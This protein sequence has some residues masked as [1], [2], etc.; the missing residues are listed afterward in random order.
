MGEGWR[1]AGATASLLNASGNGGDAG[2]GSEAEQQPRRL[3]YVNGPGMR[4]HIMQL[5]SAD[6]FSYVAMLHVFVL[7]VAVL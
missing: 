1:A 4:A 6:H 2:R 7:V 5:V 3:V